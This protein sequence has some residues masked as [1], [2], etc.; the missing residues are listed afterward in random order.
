MDPSDW[1]PSGHSYQVKIGLCLAGSISQCL[2]SLLLDPGAPG[3]I[4][5]VIKILSQ[6]IMF[7]VAEVN[8]QHCLEESDSGLR[9]L[10]KRIL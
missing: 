8:Q 9:M 2:A 1:L 5:N 3:L 7:D 4:P 10:I 6:E